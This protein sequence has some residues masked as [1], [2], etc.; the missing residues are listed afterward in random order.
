MDELH[1]ILKNHEQMYIFGT[2]QVGQTILTMC[3]SLEMDNHILGFLVSELKSNNE[4]ILGKN[5]YALSDN[6]LNTNCTVLMSVSESY[7]PDIYKLVRKTGFEKL[8]S[9][10]G[11]FSADRY[12]SYTADN[13]DIDKC[14]D[15][16]VSLPSE[17]LIARTNIIKSFLSIRHAF[18]DGF[19]YQ[20]FPLLGIRGQRPT[21]KR[22]KLY[23]L[24]KYL[25]KNSKVLDIGC[26]TGFIDLTI[27][28]KVLSV[29]GIEYS[30]GLIKTAEMTATAMKTNN[31][32][33]ICTDYKKWAACDKESF[34]LILSFAVH[35]WIDI[36][37]VEYAS[38]CMSRLNNGGHLVFESQTMP[39]DKLYFIF[40]EEFKKIGLKPVFEGDIRD[41][42]ITD[43]KF[44]VLKKE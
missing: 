43:R 34:D 35:I 5:V 28:S 37:P 27:A 21:D 32:N 14:I 41:D 24:E 4:K 39:N 2:G 20:S 6:G 29:T 8:I 30:K 10:I 15:N 22:I 7:H 33:F 38:Q 23:N 1:E 25:Y 16:S 31:V 9:V 42:S 11:Y 40:I 18:G 3:S 36:S 13:T 19:F 17:L 44:V 26:N 12:G